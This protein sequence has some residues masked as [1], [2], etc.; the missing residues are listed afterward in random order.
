MYVGAG[1]RGE[2]GSGERATPP[3]PSCAIGFA[4]GNNGAAVSGERDDATP[5]S[6]GDG[7]CCFACIG[8]GVSVSVS[9]SVSVSVSCVSC[10]YAGTEG[11]EVVGELNPARFGGGPGTGARGCS[12]GL[13]WRNGSAWTETGV[14]TDDAEAGV[15][16]GQG[17]PA[18][19]EAGTSGQ[20]GR[21][22][23]R[24]GT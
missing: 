9:M 6:A 3:A 12:G 16:R 1:S 18:A 14:E 15:K 2:A 19:V 8:A 11:S 10:V 4:T 5:G 7:D 23:P 20:L 24:R 17:G 22:E 21:L 13:V